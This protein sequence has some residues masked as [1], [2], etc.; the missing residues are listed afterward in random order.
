MAWL[1]HIKTQVTTQ[2]HSFVLFFCYKKTWTNTPY[3][4]L[5]HGN[6]LT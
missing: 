5:K 1:A 4:T 3:L 6:N 2:N